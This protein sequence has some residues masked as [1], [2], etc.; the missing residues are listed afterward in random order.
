MDLRTREGRNVHTMSSHPASISA[1]E[2]GLLAAAR[3]GDESAFRRLVEAHRSELQAH[4]YRMLGSLQDAE[5]ALQESLLRAW[6][7]LPGFEGRSSLR[8]WLYRIATNAC[9]RLLERRPKRVLPYDYAPAADPHGPLAAPLTEVPWIEPFPDAAVPVV[10]PSAEARYEQREAVELAFIAALQHLPP[11]QRAALILT[12]VLGFAPREVAEALDAPPSAVYNLLQ[13]ARK[14]TAERLPEQ[15][16]K[17]T[18]EALGDRRLREMVARYVDAW[19][20]S[21]V[22]AIRAMLA[23]DAAICMPPRPG[24]FRGPD[25]VAD[26]LRVLPLSQGRG[27]HL[28]P[29]SVN[30][31]LAFG[32]YDLDEQRGELVGHGV[33]VLQLTDAGLVREI[34]AFIGIE[35]VAQAG[36]PAELAA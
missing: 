35:Y 17:V 27:W 2:R 29:A 8:S 21:D 13:R 10:E 34:T 22:D 9:L 20:R 16:Q 3:D 11:R 23:A 24:W 19:E 5:D 7:A 30:G 25:A 32:V 31:Q 33:Q 36:L 28:R 12:D 4:C 15:P 1:Q 26:F 14:A 6:R 18:L